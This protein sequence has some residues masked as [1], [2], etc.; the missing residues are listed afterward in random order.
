MIGLLNILQ[1]LT[2]VKQTELQSYTCC[3]VSLWILD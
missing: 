2:V 3:L 1:T